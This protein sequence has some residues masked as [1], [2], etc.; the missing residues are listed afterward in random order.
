[1]WPWTRGDCAAASDS[2]G[3]LVILRLAPLRILGQLEPPANLQTV[4][5][6]FTG[7][8]RGP[9][10][11]EYPRTGIALSHR[12]SL[13]ATAGHDRSVRIY[14]IAGPTLTR[15]IIQPSATR[16]VAFARSDAII[17]TGSDVGRIDLWNLDTSVEQWRYSG[18]QAV[19]LDPLG[20]WIAS[21]SDDNR[22]R[23]LSAPTGAALAEYAF[24]E[25][26]Y[27]SRTV[28]SLTF[29][30]DG[31][32]LVARLDGSTRM[33]VWQYDGAAGLGLSELRH[34]N[35]PGNVAIVRS[36]SSGPGNAELL[37]GEGYQGRS[38]RLWNVVSGQ[39]KFS[40]EMKDQIFHTASGEGIVAA[41]DKAGNLTVNLARNGQT[42]GAIKL[43]GSPGSLAVSPS[44]RFLFVGYAKGG[45]A[46]G[47]IC[48]IASPLRCGTIP[49]DSAPLEAHF[50]PDSRILAVSQEGSTL[51][52]GGLLLCRLSDAWN[53]RKLASKSY[54]Q[55]FAFSGDSKYLAAGQR[56]GGVSIWETAQGTL[57]ATIPIVNPVREVGFLKGP[58]RILV[59][60]DG[61][62]P[63][64]L[65]AWDWRP[66]SLIVAACR[67][68]P[69]DYQP[70]EV[71]AIAPLPKRTRLC[72]AR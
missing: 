51:T 45:K 64:F 61:A 2:A 6:D 9:R 68:W 30:P 72:P 16:S 14:T 69:A 37:A 41:A 22:L 3:G 35:E 4:V 70:T 39:Q 24:Q 63:G 20:R 62:T 29:T 15:V 43:A 54:I 28:N 17:A 19:G 53:P 11:I 25:S 48:E 10:P 52:S 60:L 13:A 67:R 65:R 58:A 50:S 46:G 71:P 36:V 47:S 8:L 7:V 12:G 40:V 66:E 21:V 38:M 32:N 1:M 5:P 18:V 57:Q 42:L 49:F 59:T 27:G 33:L 44:G 31:R 55:R 56:E 26:S 34:P 23:I